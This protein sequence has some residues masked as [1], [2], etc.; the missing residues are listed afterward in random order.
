MWEL[1]WDSSSRVTQLWRGES[2]T[3]RDQ[4]CLNVRVQTHTTKWGLQGIKRAGSSFFLGVHL[5]ELSGF[6]SHEWSWGFL[7]CLFLGL[8][9]Q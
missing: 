7:K 6:L 1:V 8:E 4:D 9:S 2:E 3:N 5:T